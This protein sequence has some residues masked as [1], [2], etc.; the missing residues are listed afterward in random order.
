[1]FIRKRYYNELLN[2]IT[3]NNIKNKYNKSIVF[4]ECFNCNKENKYLEKQGDYIIYCYNCNN[5]YLN[6][7]K[8][9]KLRK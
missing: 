1:M 6:S 8:I 4:R 3:Y 2:K 5:F 9:G 7:I